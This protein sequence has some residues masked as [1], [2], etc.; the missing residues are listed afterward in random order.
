MRKTD[1][2]NCMKVKLRN[3]KFYAYNGCSYEETYNSRKTG[4]CWRNRGDEAIITRGSS[5]LGFSDTTI[6][7]RD[8]SEELIHNNDRQ[9][10]IMEIYVCTA[11]MDV[12][13]DYVCEG[14]ILHWG[15]IEPISLSNSVN[16][17]KKIETT[18]NPDILAEDK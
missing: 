16:L 12:F 6:N 2:R 3:G 14:D 5:E 1:L 4:V 10:D 17:D 9:F 15:R 13:K 8:F 11:S 7:L 18:L